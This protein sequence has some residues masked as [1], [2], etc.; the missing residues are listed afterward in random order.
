MPATPQGAVRS[1]L[2][3]SDMRMMLCGFRCALSFI[4]GPCRLSRS[5]LHKEQPRADCGRSS[6]FAR[7]LYPEPVT[8]K[9]LGSLWGHSA[10]SVSGDNF[11]QSSQRAM[12]K[13]Y[14]CPAFLTCQDVL[15]D[16]YKRGDG[17]G[18]W[19]WQEL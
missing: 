16:L 9:P 13:G 17:E 10:V 4:V 3:V 8:S 14:Y 6:K 18:S 5:N 12:P 7:C 19:K 15:P 1:L 11:W 2:W